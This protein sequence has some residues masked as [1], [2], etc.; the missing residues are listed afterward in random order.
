M[1]FNLIYNEYQ[2]VFSPVNDIF[3]ITL[4]IIIET[5]TKCI[6]LD[7]RNDDVFV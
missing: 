4:L 2:I 3:L 5:C 1:N 6:Q 7:I